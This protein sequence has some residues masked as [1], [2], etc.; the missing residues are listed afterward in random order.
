[1]LVDVFALTLQHSI[2]ITRG[3]M[4]E[5][6]CLECTGAYAYSPGKLHIL[7]QRACGGLDGCTLQ[8]SG[9]FYSCHFP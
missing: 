6:P 3:T 9:Q 2:V 7:R 5:Q 4:L 1:M 8:A